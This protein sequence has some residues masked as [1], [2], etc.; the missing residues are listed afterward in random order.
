MRCTVFV[1]IAVALTLALSSAAMAQPPSGRG[2]R[3]PGGRGG[4]G[5]PGP[6]KVEVAKGERIAWHGTL[7]GG[8]AEA[9]RLNRP[10]LLLSA[11]PHCHQ[12]PGVW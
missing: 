6:G 8:L 4:R 9:K 11:A 5:A 10:V 2:G 3:G 12:V 1:G 7:E